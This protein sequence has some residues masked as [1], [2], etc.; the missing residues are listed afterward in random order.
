MCITGLLWGL[1]VVRK[2]PYAG[3][4]KWHH[5]S[6]LLFGAVS[7]TWVFSGLLSMGPFIGS[8]SAP[9]REQRERVSG[10]PLDI[11]TV[12][13]EALRAAATTLAASVAPDRLTEIEMQ[14][15]QGRL[16][17]FGGGRIASLG[18]PGHAA[19]D[20]FPDDVI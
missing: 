4:L 17:L 7:L 1:S 11:S 8:G 5:Y 2:S 10:G 14:Q 16:F 20:R 15:F 12:T 18:L 19:F 6:G 9:A 3:L 13:T